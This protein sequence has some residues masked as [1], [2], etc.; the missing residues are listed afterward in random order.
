MV[1]HNKSPQAGLVLHW[2]EGEDRTVMGQEILLM[3]KAVSPSSSKPHFPKVKNSN[4]KDLPNC[5]INQQII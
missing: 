1:V 2:D 5:A 4:E 3:K